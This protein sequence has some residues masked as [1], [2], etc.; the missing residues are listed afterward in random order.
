M[1]KRLVVAQVEGGWGEW[2]RVYYQGAGFFGGDENVLKL[3]YD[4]FTTLY[5]YYKSKNLIYF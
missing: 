1:E 4:G 2:G 3:D 5:I